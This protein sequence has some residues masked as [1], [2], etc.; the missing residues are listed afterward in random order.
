MPYS[1]IEALHERDFLLVGQPAALDEVNDAIDSYGFDFI[2][3]PEAKV[4]FAKKGKELVGKIKEFRRGGLD[5]DDFKGLTNKGRDDLALV[6]VDAEYDGDAFRVG[7]YQFAEDLA[8]HKWSFNVP[9]NG[10]S[11]ALVIL[12][13]T[14]GNELRQV[15][16]LDALKATK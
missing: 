5:P 12:M 11:Q 10:G 8:D 1:V 4:E 13:D 6:L 9:L 15:V 3:L 2:E 14:Y 7:H 16:D